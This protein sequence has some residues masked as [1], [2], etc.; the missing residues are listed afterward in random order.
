M[1]EANCVTNLMH[2]HV[3]VFTAKSNGQRSLSTDATDIAPAA[4]EKNCF[5]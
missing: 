2:H 5:D 4:E 3:F 1:P